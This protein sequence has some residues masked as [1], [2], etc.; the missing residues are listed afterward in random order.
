MTQAA[1]IL[2]RS[3]VV[4]LDFDGPICAVFGGLSNQ[5]VAVEL[6]A[7]FPE[8]LPEGIEQ[9]PDP[10]DVLEYA[11]QFGDLATQ[12]EERLR[13][14]EV[15]AVS[16]APATPG[17]ADVLEALRRRG[18]SVVIVS[19]N[20]EAAVRA[21]LHANG[22]EAHTQGVSAR[23][24][25]ELAELKPSPFLL[26]QA[27]TNIKADAAE[28]VMIGDSATDIQAAHAAGTAVI[29]YANKP[30][31]RDRFTPHKPSAIIEHMTDLLGDGSA[32]T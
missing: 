31:K 3:R 9:S 15:R 25:G 22:L 7:L 27:I 30:G 21:Y 17:A 5:D 23:T 10:F 14:L 6:R 4:L 20:S 32:L 18:V 13:Q 19:N 24:S 2:D 28:C 8:P 29:A 11:T 26:Q 12:V 16:V 1:E